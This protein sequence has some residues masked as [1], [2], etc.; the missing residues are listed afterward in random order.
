MDDLI[1]LS[2]ICAGMCSG[3]FFEKFPKPVFVITLYITISSVIGILLYDGNDTLRAMYIVR[4]WEYLLF[5][6]ALVSLKLTINWRRLLGVT[7]LIQFSAVLSQLALGSERPQGTLAGPWES[8]ILIGLLALYIASLPATQRSKGVKLYGALI[9]MTILTKS[10]AALGG[11]LGAFALY[12]GSLRSLFVLVTGLGVFAFGLID[13]MSIG[14]LS[15]ALDPSNLN[16]LSD[17]VANAVSGSGVIALPGD[18]G[19]GGSSSLAMRFNIWLNL[20]Y[21]WSSIDQNVLKILFGIGL[22]S[23]SVVVDGFYIRLFFELGLVGCL[24]YFNILWKMIGRRELIP[25]C[26]FISVICLTLDPYS[27]SKIAYCLGAIYSAEWH[28]RRGFAC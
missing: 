17:L 19:L 25:L 26:L 23:I 5:A 16:L 13:I 6:A 14:W 21:L 20:I 15:R 12:I 4:V 1:V 10:R 9:V 22:G 24:L 28:R 7:F 11:A 2:F 3:R 27:S 18:S 8:T